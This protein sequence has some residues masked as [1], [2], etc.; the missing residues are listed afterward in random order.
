MDMELCNGLSYREM[1][2]IGVCSTPGSDH[3]PSLASNNDQGY[4]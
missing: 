3:N 4:S 1:S 2:C